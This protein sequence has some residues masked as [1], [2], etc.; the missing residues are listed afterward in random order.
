MGVNTRR[1]RYTTGNT[2]TAAALI[3][4]G[5]SLLHCSCTTDHPERVLFDIEFDA[6]MAEEIEEAKRLLHEGGCGLMVDLGLYTLAY[7][8]L[9]DKIKAAQRSART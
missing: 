7:S 9:K 1:M 5:A 8:E 2:K 3:A 4:K 6:E